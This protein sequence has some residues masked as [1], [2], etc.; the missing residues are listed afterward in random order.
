[1]SNKN[2]DTTKAAIVGGAV[3]ALAG[4]TMLNM[5][6][7]AADQRPSQQPPDAQ[8]PLGSSRN[9]DDE[10][11]GSKNTPRDGHLPSPFPQFEAPAAAP[12]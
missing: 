8:Q 11:G 2:S 1:M 3:G 4:M 6:E 7:D 10:E 5:A 12:R 9:E